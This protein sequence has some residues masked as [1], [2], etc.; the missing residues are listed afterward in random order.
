MDAAQAYRAV[1][2]VVEPVYMVGGSVR[3]TLMGRECH[4]H[5]FATPLDPDRI[6]A[7]VRAAGRRPYLVGKK[8]G[9][10]GFRVDGE[11]VEVTTF[12]TESYANGSRKPLVT[13]LGELA[14]DL[15]RRDFTINAMALQGEE[16][17][18]PFGGRDDLQARLVRAV[19]DPLAR[20][21]E[22]PL[23]MLRAVRFAAELDFEVDPA[24]ASAIAETP[25]RIL[26]VARE[27]W[28]LEL[29]RLLVGPAA[30]RG[31]RL[32]AE[33][34][35][36]RYLLPEL[37]L[38]PALP[39]PRHAAASL[40]DATLSALDAASAD[41]TARWAALLG[42][43]G[44]PYVDGAPSAGQG[45][46]GAREAARDRD[47][48]ARLIGIEIVERTALYLKWSNRR[49]AEVARLVRSGGESPA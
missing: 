18:D 16:V 7:L 21:D 35:L 25:G 5:D 8:F 36:L 12:R 47:E 45:A 30:S 15:A 22:D 23:R 34:G 31:M 6:E 49:R 17:I 1:S 28:M 46:P 19:G 37:S 26:D 43:A 14:E 2:A 10:V 29:D 48:A 9:T 3:D 42:G 38:Q 44:W 24:T 11:I 39:D 27:R 32:L 4:D 40:F 20:F 41:P 13:F 33:T